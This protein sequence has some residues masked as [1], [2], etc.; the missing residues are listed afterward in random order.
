M[1][2]LDVQQ[3]WLGY[4]ANGE[5]IVEGRLWNPKYI[6]WIG[7]VVRF[8]WDDDNVYVRVL[9]VRQ[10]TT[11]KEYL[12]GE[13]L[14]VLPGVGSYKEAEKIYHTFYTDARIKERGGIAAITIQ[15]VSQA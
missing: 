9:G 1:D 5:K 8:Y 14:N 11:L 3:P 12:Y 15:V 2:S 6:S 7:Q 13:S 10:Y 4:V